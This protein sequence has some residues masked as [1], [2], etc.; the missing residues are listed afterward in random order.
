M[1]RGSGDLFDAGCALR[2]G[3]SNRSTFT[4]D[5]NNPVGRLRRSPP[6]RK[7]VIARSPA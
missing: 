2:A 6:R 7:L 3:L 1:S 4:H 5:V